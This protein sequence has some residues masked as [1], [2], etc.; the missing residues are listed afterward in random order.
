MSI[1]LPDRKAR[2]ANDDEYGMCI[3]YSAKT[4]AKNVLVNPHVWKIIDRL[5]GK[6]IESSSF[7]VSRIQKIRLAFKNRPQCLDT[8]TI[9]IE[10]SQGSKIV[11]DK[12]TCNFIFQTEEGEKILNVF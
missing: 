5:D 9:I 4:V 8:D 2:I 7:F 6:Y 10:D 12:N 11:F 1:T 3:K